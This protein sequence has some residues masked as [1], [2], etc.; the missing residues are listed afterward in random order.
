MMKSSRI[1]NSEPALVKHTNHLHHFLNILLFVIFSASF[2]PQDSLSNDI[3]RNLV[4]VLAGCL[5]YQLS[6]STY[7][8]CS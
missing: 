8:P 7:I 5:R 3:P 2:I 1:T 4:L 6:E